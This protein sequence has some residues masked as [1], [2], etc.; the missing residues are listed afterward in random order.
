[1]Q[2]LAGNKECDRQISFELRLSGVE[3]KNAPDGMRNTGEVPYSIWGELGKFEF[4]RAWYYWVVKGPLPYDV[5]QEIFADPL[6][7]RDVRAK[8]DCGCRL[9]DNMIEWFDADGHKLVSNAEW[10]AEYEKSSDS[11]KSYMDRYK[12]DNNICLVDDVSAEGQSC[13][14][15]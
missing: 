1:M 10:E 8:G 13:I 12:I 7:K 5:A 9:E 2:N 3:I 14:T 11:L 6:G 15:S 4:H